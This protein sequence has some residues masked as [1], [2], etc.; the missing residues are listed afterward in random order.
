MKDCLLFL[1]GKYPVGHLDYYKKLCRGKFK[2]AVDGGYSFFA[3]SGLTPDILMGDFDSLKKTPKNI[4][5]RTVIFRFP[6]HKDKTD[7]ELALDYCIEKKAGRIDI[8]QPSV[9]EIDQFLGNVMLP[10]LNGYRND[11]RLPKIRILNVRYELLFVE[12][13]R[14]T[15]NKA[16]GDKISVIALSECLRY[17]CQGTEYDVTDIVLKPGQ[18]RG[19]RNKI[20]RPV[21]V[22]NLTGQA[23]FIRSYKTPRI[24]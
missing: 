11:G 20:V 21:A 8:V 14:L 7:S 2:I 3:K 10:L 5:P 12:D 19:L 13:E 22:F 9:G 16:R 17:S 4:S 1:H 15:I 6:E 18:S 24:K 23:F